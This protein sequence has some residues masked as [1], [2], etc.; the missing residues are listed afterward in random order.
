MKWFI[1]IIIASFVISGCASMM[2]S[3]SSNNTEAKLKQ[4]YDRCLIQHSNY[5][6]LC[7]SKKVKLLQEENHDIQNLE[8]YSS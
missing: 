3:T 6:D 2:R 1:P 8:R 5:P 7:Y 4:D